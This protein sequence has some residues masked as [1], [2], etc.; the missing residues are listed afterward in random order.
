MGK[1]KAFGIYEG[2]GAK[3]LAHAG[4]LKAA[5][6]K[7]TFIGVAGTSA[8]AIIA[9]LIAAGYKADEIYSPDNPDSVFRTNLTDLLDATEWRHVRSLR[10][11]FF[12]DENHDDAFPIL[13]LTAIIVLV[14]VLVLLLPSIFLYSPQIAWCSRRFV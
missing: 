4:A 9:S 14:S 11:E 10:D 13:Q 3:G 1:T 8:G 12:A 2:G 6:E 7:F 5:E